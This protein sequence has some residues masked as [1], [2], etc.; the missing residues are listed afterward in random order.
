M[1]ENK[2]RRYRT[3]RR[4]GTALNAKLPYLT[5]QGPILYDR[6]RRVE[7]RN[8]VVVDPVKEMISRLI[9]RWAKNPAD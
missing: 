4:V 8:A 2:E 6:R 1:A 9:E 5:K 3:E 7:R